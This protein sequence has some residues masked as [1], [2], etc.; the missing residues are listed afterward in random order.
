[1]SKLSRDLKLEKLKVLS[2]IIKDLKSHLQRDAKVHLKKKTPIQR[3]EVLKMLMVIKKIVHMF[4][5]SMIRIVKIM[6]CHPEA[7]IL[8]IVKVM[9]AVIQK[10]QIWQITTQ[11][12][13]S[14]N[15]QRQSI[16]LQISIVFQQNQSSKS[17]KMQLIKTKRIWKKHKRQFSL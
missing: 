6:K 16:Q 9:I 12:K 1:M 11:K 13:R 15:F 5:Q 17:C 7:Q 3:K 14:I 2:V 8:S 4:N 10:K